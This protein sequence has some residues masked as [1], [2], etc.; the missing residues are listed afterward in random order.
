VN[1]PPNSDTILN[2]TASRQRHPHHD[3]CAAG[4]DVGAEQGDGEDEAAT[5]VG[6][7]GEQD[8]VRISPMSPFAGRL[9]ATAM[10][11]FT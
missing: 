11:S 7:V 10:T 9:L 3:L 1:P 2:Q 8:R 5:H 4:E 6:D